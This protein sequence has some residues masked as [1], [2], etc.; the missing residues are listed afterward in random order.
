MS[1]P[2]HE[3]LKNHTIPQVQPNFTM[4]VSLYRLQIHFCRKSNL[5]ANTRFLT[6]IFTQ[7]KQFLLK[8]TSFCSEF[9]QSSD[10]KMT[11]K[12]PGSTTGSS[13]QSTPCWSFQMLQISLLRLPCLWYLL[14]PNT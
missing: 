10:L 6:K 7:K 12:A 3:M 5:V 14:I 8:T 9:I 11:G 13:L 2:A 1:I 4:C